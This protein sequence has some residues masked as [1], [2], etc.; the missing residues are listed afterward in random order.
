[1]STV[2]S[3]GKTPDLNFK[4]LC[5]K[6]RMVMD[7]N[8]N[9]TVRSVEVS[10]NLIINNKLEVRGQIQGFMND[11]KLVFNENVESAKFYSAQDEFTETFNMEEGVNSA[12]IE[13]I[14]NEFLNFD[15]TTLE[16]VTSPCVGEID[17]VDSISGNI[18]YVP[19]NN[20]AH[21]DSFQY[22]IKDSQGIDHL[23]TQMICVPEA[24]ICEL[25]EVFPRQPYSNANMYP[26]GQRLWLGGPPGDYLNESI[27]YSFLGVQSDNK[28]V[29][30]GDNDDNPVIHRFNA[31]R[32]WDLTFGN[33]DGETVVSLDDATPTL[34]AGQYFTLTTPTMHYYVWFD[35][36]NSSTDPAPYG[37]TLTGIEV[38]IATGDSIS[39][40]RDKMRIAIDGNPDFSAVNF[41]AEG[42]TV[43][44]TAGS[45]PTG[46]GGG[47]VDLVQLLPGI[48]QRYYHGKSLS[49][50]N[51]DSIYVM[52]IWQSPTRFAVAKIL[53]NG[54]GLDMSYN[55]TGYTPPI[56]GEFEGYHT[57]S[58]HMILLPDQSII[59]LWV[60]GSNVG[61]MTRWNSSGA[62]M[63]TVS[64]A[65]PFGSSR[66]ALSFDYSSNNS[67]IYLGYA[68]FSGS[69]AV[70]AYDYNGNVD[71]T[72]GVSG[73]STYTAPSSSCGSISD[74][75][76]SHIKVG[77]DGYIYCPVSAWPT[78]GPCYMSYGL[79]RI[80][81][82]GTLDTSYGDNGL[83]IW[84]RSEI[85]DYITGWLAHVIFDTIHGHTLNV[86]S[87]EL[88][89]SSFS[90]ARYEV[91]IIE[92]DENGN[93]VD[94]TLAANPPS[95]TE[96][97]KM[98]QYPYDVIPREDGTIIWAGEV[99]GGGNSAEYFGS[100]IGE[101]TCS[102]ITYIP[103][104]RPW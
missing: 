30:V 98:Y 84:N 35:L 45:G 36:D 3:F 89:D 73:V 48:N 2:K 100:T 95:G 1:M 33:V 38:D 43:T 4:T 76:V 71:M 94:T 20:V 101:F 53:P 83:F 59:A 31:D 27:R 75:N 72:F 29:V 80:D 16:I 39:I 10:K 19:N 8:N 69:F 42:I 70:V 87:A 65:Q 28:V 54:S 77:P 78:S 74:D 9:L 68:D 92:V 90:G 97:N 7:K 32:S 103:Q 91:I 88:Y 14:Q 40:M 60:N 62:Q 26:N 66:R 11:G 61:Q 22:K 41:G 18:F 13:P 85:N 104:N 12:I 64:Q 79:Y 99:Y 37:G 46:N 24:I 15:T 63:W 5:C 58:R 81:P 86:I 34:M 50:G 52:A 6:N 44:N 56:N 21:I 82:N 57:Y 25:T 96:P 47:K 67:R 23:V 51:D 55:G 17:S 93:L 49:I 102:V